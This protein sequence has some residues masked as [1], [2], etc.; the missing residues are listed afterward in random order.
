MQR[1]VPEGEKAVR[2]PRFTVFTASFNRAHTLH[3]VFESLQQ[4]SFRDFEWVLIDDGS[5]DTTADL[6]AEWI[7]RASFPIIY[8]Y[9]KNSGKHIAVNQGL[10]LSRGE[11]FLI[12]DS[13][14]CFTPD[15][16]ERMI[17]AWE[18]IED[19]S[20]Y[21]GILTLSQ[22]D[23]GVVEGDRFPHSPMD[24]DALILERELKSNGERWGFHRT[25]VLRQFHFPADPEVR[26]V[27]ENIVWYAIARHYRLRCVNDPLRVYTQDSNN[28]LTKSDLSVKA[29]VYAYYYVIF[30]SYFSFFGKDPLYFVKMALLYWRYKFH[31]PA[32][33]R[34]Q[35]TKELC[36]HLGPISCEKALVPRF[37]FTLAAM[38]GLLLFG[39]DRLRGRRAC[40]R[41]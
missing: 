34:L 15:A 13:D 29:A 11:F 28:Q 36:A 2:G 9:Q 4:Q 17:A 14:D 35:R 33:N 19:K 38:P 18:T 40:W 1:G 25:D 10:S 6:V 7:S 5:T 39:W 26:F 22:S 12:I 41:A 16:L 3:R 24:S 30:F 32:D 8:M 37:C 21:T 31:M 23:Q 20:A 27:P